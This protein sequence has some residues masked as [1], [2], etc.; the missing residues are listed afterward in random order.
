MMLF[1]LTTFVAI[2]QRLV[3]A[4]KDTD[5]WAAS[6][7][8]RPQDSVRPVRSPYSFRLVY[9][10]TLA[11]YSPLRIFSRALELKSAIN[12]IAPQGAREPGGGCQW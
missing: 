1:S 6:M 2:E 10:G 7:P 12:F 11:E 8:V 3:D 4:K 5:R 9:Q